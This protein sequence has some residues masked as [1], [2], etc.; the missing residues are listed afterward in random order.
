M[1]EKFIADYPGL[2]AAILLALATL[3]VTLAKLL[4]SAYSRRI[5][6]KLKAMSQRNDSQ[7]KT[8]GRVASDVRKLESIPA[9]LARME[10]HFNDCEGRA[11]ERHGKLLDAVSALV[12]SHEVLAQRVDALEAKMPNGELKALAEAYTKLAEQ[13]ARRARK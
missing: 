7:D 1:I 6:E 4:W 9:T 10:A 11:S 5:E 13:K 3:I 12:T 2:S 8:I